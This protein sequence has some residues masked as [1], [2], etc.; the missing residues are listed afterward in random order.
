MRGGWHRST[1]G[2]AL[3]APALCLAGITTAVARS[4]PPSAAIRDTI[5]ASRTA[6]PV[7]ESSLD[8]TPV[9]V[10]IPAIGVDADMGS[11]GLN[12][13]GTLE[14]PPYDRAGWFRGEPK[15]G[16]TGP[17]VIAAHVDSTAGPAVFAG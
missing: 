1:A 6:V 2:L 10:R 5:V 17:A 8:G 16:E 13:D 12:A 11:L 14:V 3:L 4:T 15:P 7:E 9:R